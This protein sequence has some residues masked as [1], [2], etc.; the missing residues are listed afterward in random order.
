MASL[1]VDGSSVD[2]VM[3]NGKVVDEIKFRPTRRDY[4]VTLWKRAVAPVTT[5]LTYEMDGVDDAIHLKDEIV[6]NIG[7][8]MQFDIIVH[9]PLKTAYILCS[10]TDTNV[11][12]W[13][14]GTD[15]KI[16]VGVSYTTLVSVDGITYGKEIE[17]V[18]GQKLTVY[19]KATKIARFGRFGD[20]AGETGRES[21]I[22]IS[23]IIFGDGSVH[24]YPV[25]DG[26]ANNPLIRNTG[27]GPNAALVN[28]QSSGWSGSNVPVSPVP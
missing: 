10:E 20:K 1:N 11:A 28:G 5:G 16:V 25:N 2:N 27:S 3:Y 14:A 13:G 22:T 4:Y 23:N 24:T 15:N 7:D 18:I 8:I 26:W 12:L 9:K 21:N 19:V 6:S 17:Y